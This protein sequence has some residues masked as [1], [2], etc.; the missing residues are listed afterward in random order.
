VADGIATAA[1]SENWRDGPLCLVPDNENRA[2]YIRPAFD[3]DGV[4]AFTLAACML[5]ILQTGTFGA[6]LTSVITLVAAIARRHSI[7]EVL[8]GRWFLLLFPALAVSST[9]WSEVP[10]ETLKHSAEYALTILAAILLAASAN[11]RSVLY[12]MF[13]AFTLYVAVS[14]AVGDVVAVGT[15]GAS[16]VSGLSDSKNEQADLAAT[17]FVISVSVFLI[18][19]KMHKPALCAAAMAAGG[20]EIYA[21]TAALSAGALAGLAAAMAALVLLLALCQAA[22]SLRALLIGT[23]GAIAALLAVGFVA[24][25]ADVQ[26]WLADAFG[27]DATLTGRTY[28]WARA[29]EFITENPLLGSGFAAFWQHGNLDAEGLWQ[30]A[31]I[32][33]REGFNFHSTMY[34]T[35]V[36]LGWLGAIVFALTIAA[37]LL[38]ITADYIRRPTLLACFWL[39]MAVYLLARMPIESIGLT[40]FY[41]STVL[42]FA[43]LGSASRPLQFLLRARPTAA[44]RDRVLP[45]PG[46]TRP[47]SPHYV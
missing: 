30:F 41:F 3:W 36:G 40:E 6:L 35:L 18:G 7:G 1:V 15:T 37:G 34:D 2:F 19:W 13:W 39:S 38:K 5:F 11:Q 47:S 14:L 10:F 26:D 21:T 33:S 31:H 20:L 46:L 17:G 25:N 24:I 12:G 42:L 28:L 43:L 32:T 4:F 22:R 8:R 29:R 23:I 45:W 9:L 44:I 16:A 27:K